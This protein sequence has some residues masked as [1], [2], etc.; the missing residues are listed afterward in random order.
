MPLPTKVGSGRGL[1]H[2]RFRPTDVGGL[3]IWVDASRPVNCSRGM[4]CAVASSQYGEVTS[5]ASL[6]GGAQDWAIAVW[7]KL[8]SKGALR[9]FV[10]KDN[11]GAGEYC[12][13]Y[14]N[15]SDRFELLVYSAINTPVSIL[16][17][18]LGSP[19]TGTW[20][21]LT[22]SYDNTAHVA[23]LSV[24]AGTA[25]TGSVTSVAA[26][27]AAFRIGADVRNA[28]SSLHDGMLDSVGF[29]HRTLTLSG[30][31]ND[32]ELLYNGG[33]GQRY[34]QL[35]TAQKTSLQSWYDLEEYTGSSRQDSQ[36]SNTISAGSLGT[37]G[38]G[39][40]TFNVDGDHLE[41]LPDYS[42]Q[43]HPGSGVASTNSPVFKKS[44]Y[45]NLNA[46]RFDAPSQMTFAGPS[47]GRGLTVFMVFAPDSNSSAGR[48][49]LCSTSNNWLLGPYNNNAQHYAGNFI[50]VQTA[51][52]TNKMVLLTL[53]EGASSSTLYLNGAVVGSSAAESNTLAIPA[54]SAGG[55]FGENALADLG[56][57]LIYNT[58]LQEELRKPIDAY[59][60]QKWGILV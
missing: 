53:V 42:G 3:Q 21:L 44:L 20:Y 31:G 28:G 10:S 36:G 48:R 51:M 25:D 46:L 14:N 39:V 30:A 13:R 55:A 19:S 37:H 12:L 33:S 23:S 22:A 18:T 32:A 2:T 4:H 17:N 35:S 24:N 26:G 34:A 49:L 59:C 6:Q 40:T 38:V 8:D 29:W 57:M 16:A 11:T 7:I 15:S 58:A 43:N 54:F 9:T 41:L 52:A 5:V 47:F 45:N 1:L 60:I 27:A 56:E 50:N